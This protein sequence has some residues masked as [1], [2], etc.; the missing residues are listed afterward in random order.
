LADAAARGLAPDP[1]TLQAVHPAAQV[2]I[3]KVQESEARPS[4]RR[5]R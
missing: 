3:Q 4:T 2:T 5:Q 1:P